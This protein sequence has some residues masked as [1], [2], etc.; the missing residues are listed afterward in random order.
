MPDDTGTTIAPA[1]TPGEWSEGTGARYALQWDGQEAREWHDGWTRWE[2]L[3]PD[4]AHPL[5]AIANAA[6][7]DDD[8][9]K[10]TRADVAAVLA[11]VAAAENEDRGFGTDDDTRRARALAA[12]LVALLPRD[13]K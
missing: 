12:K 13:T 9:R 4:D 6:L 3:G 2:T 5:A 1:L 11:C 8:P 7:P 10:I